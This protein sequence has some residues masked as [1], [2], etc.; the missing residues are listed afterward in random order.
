MNNEDFKKGIE[1]LKRIHITDAEKARMLKNI[2]ATPIRSPYM[3]RVPVFTFVYSF[4][5]IISLSGLTYASGD[6]IPGDALYSIKIRV[7]EPI[8]DVV[9]S[10]PEKK[11]V[12]EEKKVI[13]RINEAEK[14]EKKDELD[15]KR[16]VE[17]ER[18]VEKSSRAFIK[19][20]KE[21]NGEKIEDRK[22]EFRKKFQVKENNDVSKVEKLKR[23]AVEIIDEN[24]DSRKGANN[25]RD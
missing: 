20:V 1:E 10:A 18:R 21:A 13:K 17:L 24:D 2:F 25:D 14:L 5:L 7:V 11:I 3:K 8:L 19:A 4:I 22:T 16:A 23:V 6:S 12:W 9:N 15:D